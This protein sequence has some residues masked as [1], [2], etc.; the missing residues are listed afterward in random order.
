VVPDLDVWPD[1]DGR[2][3]APRRGEPPRGPALLEDAALLRMA[4]DGWSFEEIHAA[5]RHT[6][7]ERLSESTL[8]AA[9]STVVMGSAP[10]RHDY[11]DHVPWRVRECH[12]G[13]APLQL[14]R[15]LGRRSV[16]VPLPTASLARLD[17]WLA[18]LALERRVVAYHP[19]S[20]EGF[21][22]VDESLRSG[23]RPEIPVRVQLV[24]WVPDGARVD[25]GPG[26]PGG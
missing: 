14:L 3:A 25:L 26:R 9:L 23:P 19:A 7:G 2:L 24:E 20:D 8:A 17:A 16:G 22:Y 6:T 13:S 12:Q 10:S 4:R 15:L 1:W 11:W 5:C 21:W 18:A